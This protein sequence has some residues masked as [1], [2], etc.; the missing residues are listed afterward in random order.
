M[1]PKSESQIKVMRIIAR[2][3]VGGPAVQV[4][5]LM[6]NLDRETFEQ[7][8]YAGFCAPDELDYL[9][10]SA[11][12]IQ[13]T[14]VPGLGRH[15]NATSDIR[16][17]FFLIKEIR[18]FRPE[19]IH[20]HT[21]KAGFLGRIAS[22][23]SGHR[24]IRIH[25]FHGHLL[26]GYFSKNKTKLVVFAEY[27]LAK[28]TTCLLAVGNQVRQDLLVKKIGASSKFGVMPPGITLGNPLERI[29]SKI[30]LGLDPEK[31]HCAFIGRITQIKRP[32]RFLDA[33]SELR[34]TAPAVQ[35]F[36]A[37]E[38]DL[39]EYMKN[40]IK[41]ES[42]PVT[43]L[44]W[45]TNIELVLSASDIVVLTSD[46]E[47][48]PISLIQAGMFGIPVV[49]TNVGSVSEIVIHNETGL[50]TT[51]ASH[52]IAQAIKLLADNPL[53]RKELGKSALQFTKS[54]FSSERL[55]RDHENLYLVLIKN[56]ANS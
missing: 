15:I 36:A 51:L 56:L 21:A 54:N 33:V 38:G 23:I 24:S 14:K 45:Q 31:I 32:D 43:L 49:S 16:A 9:E 35:F 20:T 25:T 17:L 13:V 7:R 4:S 1:S 29:E 44:G 55:S 50:V 22:I 12:D 42:L 39:Y 10:T 28:F 48:T 27:L 11:K 34:T 2:M 40:R 46:N 37:G 6:R 53:L 5:G 52:D 26:N 8:L 18:E 41:Q 3:N 47:G 19:I 30:Q